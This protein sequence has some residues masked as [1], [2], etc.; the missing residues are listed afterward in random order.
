MIPAELPRDYITNKRSDS[1]GKAVG[2]RPECRSP[3]NR[4]AGRL[5][6]GTAVGFDRN[7]HH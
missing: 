7:M 1:S 4:N 5:P 3:S 6:A 2:I